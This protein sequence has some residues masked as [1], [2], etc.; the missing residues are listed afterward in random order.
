MKATETYYESPKTSKRQ[1]KQGLHFMLEIFL[2]VQTF[3]FFVH[4]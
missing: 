4:K 2:T 3:L 1:L